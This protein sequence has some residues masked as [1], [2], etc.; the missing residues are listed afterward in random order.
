MTEIKRYEMD[1]DDPL[2]ID[3]RKVQSKDGEFVTYEDHAT[4]V[5]ALQEQV[6]ALAADC[7][8]KLHSDLYIAIR[9]MSELEALD[10]KHLTICYMP[11][12]ETSKLNFN[13]IMPSHVSAKVTD[14]LYW[15]RVNLTVA[16]IDSEESRRAYQVLNRSGFTYDFEFIPHVTIC[17]GDKTSEYR[18]IIGEEII[19]GNPYIRVRPSKKKNPATDAVLREIRADGAM[20]CGVHLREWYDYQVE[21]RSEEFAAAIRAGEQP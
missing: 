10:D 2:F 7:S 15:E 14:V 13:E 3:I 19:I 17:Q 16:L 9:T 5:A 4:I 20:A 18:G 11:A 12:S 8:K 6:R 1:C 21:E